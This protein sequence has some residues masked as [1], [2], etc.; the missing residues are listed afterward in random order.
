MLDLVAADRDEIEHGN[1]AR[2]L[3]AVLA[4][5]RHAEPLHRPDHLLERG[6][7]L[8]HSRATLPCSISS[9]SAAPACCPPTT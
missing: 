9:R 2:D 1:V 3:Q 8:A 4:R 5:H 7:A 6:R